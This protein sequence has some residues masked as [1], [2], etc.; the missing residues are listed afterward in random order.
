VTLEID[1]IFSSDRLT[2]RNGHALDGKVAFELG[3]DLAVYGLRPPALPNDSL[4][5]G[6]EECSSRR[7]AKHLPHDRFVRKWLQLRINAWLRHRVVDEGVTPEFLRSIDVRTCPVTGVELTHGTGE[8]SDWSVDRLNNDGAYAQGNLAVI[9]AL[10]NKAKG[11]KTFE[12]V[13]HLAQADQD[14]VEGLAP[15]QWAR[16]AAMMVTP[17]HLGTKRL[18][19]FPYPLRPRP[20]VP[21]VFEQALQ[22]TLVAQCNGGPKAVLGKL[23]DA[24][25]TPARQKQFHQLVNKVRRKSLKLV[26]WPTVWLSKEVWAAFEDFVVTMPEAEAHRMRNTMSRHGKHVG[27]EWSTPDISSWHLDRR[28]Y[29]PGYRPPT[30]ET[31]VEGMRQGCDLAALDDIARELDR[32]ADVLG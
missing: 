1:P 8:P 31:V 13:V 2:E 22:W 28:G 6:Y 24:C 10:A 21:L 19:L 16:M 4:L 12:E 25:T 11:R 23:K 14:V 7:A 30:T 18:P 17:C 15:G 3:W 32:A 27:P 29:L 9:S 20:A 5:A 26:D